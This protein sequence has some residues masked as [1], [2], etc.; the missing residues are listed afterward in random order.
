MELHTSDTIPVEVSGNE[1]FDL[2]IPGLEGINFNSLDE[3]VFDNDAT[4]VIDED[5]ESSNISSDSDEEGSISDI[6][7]DD[8]KFDDDDGYD[9][10]DEFDEDGFDEDDIEF[11]DDSGSETIDNETSE[12]ELSDEEMEHEDVDEMEDFIVNDDGESI[13]HEKEASIYELECDDEDDGQDIPRHIYDEDIGGQSIAQSVIAASVVSGFAAS[14]KRSTWVP[15][16]LG[17]AAMGIVGFAVYYFMRR[18]NQLQKKIRILEENQDM[19]LNDKDVEAITTKVLEDILDEEGK[20]DDETLEAPVGMEENYNSDSTSSFIH[21]ESKIEE[22][23][24]PKSRIEMVEVFENYGT[25]VDSKNTVFAEV[26]SEE[27]VLDEVE[28][29]EVVLD[30]VESEEVV[31]DEVE[32]QEVVVDE[33]ESEEVVVDEVESEEVVV[34]EVKPIED[35]V[36]EVKPIEDIVPEVKPIE[37]IVP[38]VEPLT[39]VENKDEYSTPIAE[40]IVREEQ[41]V[42]EK[43]DIGDKIEE[44]PSLRRRRGRP[45]KE[46]SL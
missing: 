31:V 32:S 7:E 34:Y 44:V 19:S 4:I 30:E 15:V 23:D 18:F 39:I 3:E 42:E 24:I 33:V 21:V 36:P 26:E 12:E 29:E 27:V 40:T 13:D 22:P 2:E 17:V 1:N 8:D 35:N 43:Y 10:G 20:E 6:E 11:I 14:R 25:E 38:K 9:D 16:V 5:M 45:K 46:D 41:I 37:Y 28:S